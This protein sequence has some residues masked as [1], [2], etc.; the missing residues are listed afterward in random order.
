VSLHSHTL[1]SRETLSFVPRHVP[2]IPVLGPLVA[3]Q[4]RKYR[5]YFGRELD[6]H[7][8]WWTPPLAARSAWELEAEQIRS[9]GFAPL[10][11]LTDHDSLDAPE[12]LRVLDP[13]IPVPL[14]VEWTV[15]LERTFIHL[16]V[17]NL[18]GNTARQL[19]NAMQEFTARP[20]ELLL[21]ALL[22]SLHHEPDVL[23]VFNHPLW[24]EGC[25]GKEEHARLVGGFF[26]RHGDRIHALEFNGLRPW[27]ENREVLRLGEKWGVPV[28]SG[29][30]RHG[31]EPNACLNL[32]TA[33][34]FSE[35]VAE[36]RGGAPSRMLVCPQYREPHFLRCYE[37]M[38]DALAPLPGE[39]G[40]E[41]WTG[42]VFY[43]NEQGEVLSLA[44]MWRGQGPAVVTFFVA[45]VHFISNPSMRSMM[46]AV[47][48]DRREL[49]L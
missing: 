8:V 37:V 27:G 28:V 45:L 16:G 47:L 25:I 26:A 49:A 4:E 32:T 29:G 48:A 46:R 18:P 33:D 2:K 15:P 30:D 43:E 35:F 22:D 36:L 31:L 24:D 41:H 5:E 9:L 7:R 38:R 11:S 13:A 40:R 42:R 39:P 3:V 1:H 23:V 14:S 10:V 34:T 6:Y 17:H 21:R 12:L 19:M 44:E 20:T